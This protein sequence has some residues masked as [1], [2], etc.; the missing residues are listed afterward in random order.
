L[1]TAKT[2]EYLRE[3]AASKSKVGPAGPAGS[4]PRVYLAITRSRPAAGTY[5][6]PARPS[7]RG[8]RCGRARSTHR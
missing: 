8:A 2:A 1:P 6:T 5:I 7:D 4:A 3:V